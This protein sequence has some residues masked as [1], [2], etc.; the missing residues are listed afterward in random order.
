MRR[1]FCLYILSNLLLIVM[2]Q[3]TYAQIPLRL[4]ITSGINFSNQSFSRALYT[5]NHPQAYRTGFT[6]GG[7]VELGIYKNWYIHSEPR[8]IQRGT[9]F[10][11]FIVTGDD[12]L[13]TGTT[14]ATYKIDYFELPILLKIL[15]NSYE[16]KPFFFIGPTFGT[17]SY[18]KIET[19][20]THVLD[21]PNT[22]TIDIKNDV[23]S[24]EVSF[25]IGSGAEYQ[26]LPKVALFADARY[27]RSLNNVYNSAIV[28]S[29]KSYGFSVQIGL[30]FD[31]SESAPVQII[32]EQSAIKPVTLDTDG[33]GLLDSD[34]INTYNTNPFRAD[35]DNDGL[36]DGEEILT[37]KTNPLNPDTD[38]DN[39]TDGDEVLKYKTNPLDPDTDHGS[40]K[41]GI[42]VGR[43][44]NPLNPA[45][46]VPK[47]EEI[48][49]EIGKSIVL[50]GI[51]FKTASAEIS[52]ASTAIL[53]KAYNTLNQNTEI[54]VEIQGHTD[55]VGKKTY[56]MKLSSARANSVKEYL[57]QRGISANRITTKGFGFDKPID[58]NKTSEGRQKNR[59]IEF[60]RIK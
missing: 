4:G 37:N 46:D 40:I 26:I 59:R 50:E 45:D 47:K 9:I 1:T 12:P 13:P 36:K 28:P 33:D 5:G 42:E 3:L 18:A 53:E 6:L 29:A 32:A 20:G 60:F 30:L 31:I 39:L 23:N 35:T 43:G 44:T 57:V 10:Q 8:F 19:P 48:K 15:F 7:V 21:K 2:C 38:G 16:I 49:M 58:S 27:S 14:D 52:P 54:V 22:S 25:D 41:D 17:N 56:N 24:F 11:N 34:E 55:N 51:V